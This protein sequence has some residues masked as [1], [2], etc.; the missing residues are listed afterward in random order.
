MKILIAIRDTV[1]SAEVN[2]NKPLNF[3]L[4]Q[5]F[6]NP[7]NS[8]TNIGFR[9]PPA[10]GQVANSRFVSLKVYDVLGREVATLLNEEKPEGYHTIKFDASVL[11]SGI[12][13]YKLKIG[14]IIKS[15]KMLLLR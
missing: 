1:T 13:F 4:E 11:P 9:I 12:Y 15:K 7:F 10:G 5:N 3:T 6:P 14:N 2:N 8:I